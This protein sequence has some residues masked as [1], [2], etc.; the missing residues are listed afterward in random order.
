MRAAAE[1]GLQDYK[2]SSTITACS[3]TTM[4]SSSSSIVASEE[5]HHF[6]NIL[7]QASVV[8]LVKFNARVVPVCWTPPASDLTGLDLETWGWFRGSAGSESLCQSRGWTH[9]AASVGLGRFG[10]SRL[11]SSCETRAKPLALV[12]H[13]RRFPSGAFFLDSPLPGRCVRGFRRFPRF[14]GLSTSHLTRSRR[15]FTCWLE[16]DVYQ[17]LPEFHGQCWWIVFVSSQLCSMHHEPAVLSARLRVSAL[18]STSSSTNSAAALWTCMRITL[19]CVSVL[20]RN[21]PSDLCI[22]EE[23]RIFSYFWLRCHI[24]GSQQ[25]CLSARFVNLR[26]FSS[27]VSWTMVLGRCA[28]MLIWQTPLSVL[29]IAPLS[30]F[31][32]NARPQAQRVSGGGL[33]VGAWNWVHRLLLSRKSHD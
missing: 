15:S 24:Q 3:S 10:A 18:G 2:F 19:S 17:T 6:F 11:S 32:E 12:E 28:R 4:S 25:F 26:G 14:E 23:R 8:Q 31:S 5:R 29:L 22:P 30:R 20:L 9:G 21:R 16:N 1:S 33:P 13:C 7:T 27:V